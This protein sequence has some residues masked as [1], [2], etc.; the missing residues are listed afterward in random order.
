[1]SHPYQEHRAH[2]HDKARAHH[3]VRHYAS[4]G[5]VHSEVGEHEEDV[6][7]DKAMIKGAL[8]KHEKKLHKGE[9]LTPLKH[10]GHVDGKKPKHHLGKRAHRARGGRT[11]HKGKTVINIHAGGPHALGGAPPMPVPMPGPAVPPPAA[12]PP[13]GPPPGLGGPPPGLGAGPP[14]GLRPPMPPMRARG[15]KVPGGVRDQGPGDKMPENPPGWTESAKH[16]TPV[17]HLEA[18]GTEKSNLGRGKPVT[19]AHGGKVKNASNAVHEAPAFGG[20]PTVSRASPT[21]KPVGGQTRVSQ[22]QKADGGHFANIPAGGKSG[23][24]RLQ[25]AHRAAS[26]ARP[27][28]Y[29]P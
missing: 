7:E 24:G 12:L 11:R 6:R 26:G 13:P 17:Q 29:A 16:K 14:P 9:P 5:A 19:Y 18:K 4:G 28:E 27:R 1:M 20:K 3:L 22:P 10:G 2:K 15:G 23:I 21:V 25:K 8:H